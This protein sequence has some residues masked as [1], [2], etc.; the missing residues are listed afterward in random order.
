[1]TLSKPSE[2]YRE[3]YLFDMEASGFMYACLRFSSAELIKSLKIVSDNRDEKVGMNRQRVSDLV[4]QHIDSIDR[5]AG[6]LIALNDEVA[7]LSPTLESW[8]QLIAMAHFSQTQKN[9]LRVLWRYLMNRDFDAATLLQQLQ[10]QTAGAI[11]KN[12]EQ[13]SHQNSVGL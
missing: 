13:H 7:G 3:E 2:D 4:N 12:L 10:G 1:M 6:A 11:I 9:R 8:Q 5:Q